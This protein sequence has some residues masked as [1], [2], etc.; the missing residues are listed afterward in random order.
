MAS[1]SLPPSQRTYLPT[2]DG[3]RAI[4]ILAVIACHSI[5]LTQPGGLLPNHRLYVVV[6]TLRHGVD[7]FFA[8]SGFLITRLLVEELDATKSIS[9]ALFYTRRAFRILPLI[10]LYLMTLLALG[11]F[12]PGL[13]APWEVA[14]SLLFARNYLAHLNGPATLHF[15]SLAVEEHFYLL[16]PPL[17]AVLGARRAFWAAATLALAVGVWRYIDARYAL[18]A[19]AFEPYADARYRTD[20]RLDGLLLGALMALGWGRLQQ[21]RPKL[22]RVPLSGLLLVGIIGAGFSH[23]PIS[24]SALSLL[25]AALVAGTVLVPSSPWA[26]FLEWAPLRWI[27]RHSY[28]LYVWQTLLLQAPQVSLSQRAVGSGAGWLTLAYLADLGW[29]LGL[30]VLSHRFVELP[31]QHQGRRLVQA[32]SR[33]LTGAEAESG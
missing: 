6:G 14:S 17:L 26:H 3:W 10:L 30:S 24:G 9:L 15:W 8:I 22:E 27:G 29:A 1:E 33:A 18:F 25:F 31:L 21:L 7:L 2:L 13:V 4:A 12:V 32:R 16:W 20:T 19:S 23:S 11:V 5:H 28:S